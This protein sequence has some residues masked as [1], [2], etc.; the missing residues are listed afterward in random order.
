LRYTSPPQNPTPGVH[1]YLI[2]SHTT[3]AVK[4]GRSR[5]PERRLKQL[6]TGSPYK[7]R[8]ILVLKD[9]GHLEGM[10]HERLRR[11][12]T[13]GGEEWFAYDSLPELPEW[14]WD[15]LDLEVVDWWWTETGCCPPIKPKEET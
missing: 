8:I 3:G 10:L 13:R 5:D 6:Q 15:K 14:I 11:G 12:R 2:Q 7:L 9:Q 1:L 4:I